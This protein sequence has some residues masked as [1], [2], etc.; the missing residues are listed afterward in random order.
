[1]STRLVPIDR[2]GFLGVGTASGLL[3][4]SLPSV[5]RA[6]ARGSGSDRTKADGAI[7]VWLGG[8]PATIDMWDLKPAAP[9]E[10]R[11]EFKSDRHEGTGRAHLR[12]PSRRSPG[13]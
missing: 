13:E 10:Y 7:L 6:E 11:G 3:G 2:R 4:L 8:G 12:T 5:L 1:M 9:E